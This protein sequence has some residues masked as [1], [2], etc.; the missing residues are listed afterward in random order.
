MQLK[1]VQSKTKISVL[2]TY[3]VRRLIV[4]VVEWC[5]QNFGVRKYCPKF[6]FEITKERKNENAGWY[7]VARHDPK[8]TVNLSCNTDILDLFDT[9]IH[10]Y[11]HYLVPNFT[12]IY[13]QFENEYSYQTHPLEIEAQQ[14]A[15]KYR[16][17]CFNQIKKDL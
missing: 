7:L 2:Y 5:M 1:N 4:M 12:E 11:T 13:T 16:R 17:K 14:Q 3:Q 15:K 9:I 8:I 10:E 6:E